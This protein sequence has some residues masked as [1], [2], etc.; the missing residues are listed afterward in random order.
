MIL[1]VFIG[2]FHDFHHPFW[3]FPPIFFGNAYIVLHRH[4]GFFSAKIVCVFF[5]GSFYCAVPMECISHQLI[6]KAGGFLCF[7]L[8]IL[9]KAGEP[10]KIFL[11][12]P[13][14]S[15]YIKNV[16]W[17]L[18]PTTLEN[19][20]FVLNLKITWLTKENLPKLHFPVQNVTFQWFL[21]LNPSLMALKIGSL[22][23][24]HPYKWSVSHLPPTSTYHR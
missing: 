4:H 3:G 16:I 9:P 19:Y 1:G 14:K 11:K 13:K 6:V 5:G 8:N 18:T 23:L 22:W 2:V 12:H 17:Y 7:I 10:P 20:R 24:F 21:P 15:L